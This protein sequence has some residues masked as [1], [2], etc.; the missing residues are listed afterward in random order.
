[1]YWWCRFDGQTELPNND[2]IFNTEDVMSWLQHESVL[3]GGELTGVAEII[4]WR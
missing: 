4:K 2:D 1:M 3:Q